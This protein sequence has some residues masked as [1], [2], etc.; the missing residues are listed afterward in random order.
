[1]FTGIITDIGCI[2]SLEKKD[3]VRLVISTAYDTNSIAMGAS[4]AVSGVCLTVVDKGPGWFAADVSAETFSC[5]AVGSWYE[6][7]PVNLER[8]LKVGDELGGHIVSGHVD[9]VGEIRDILQIDG[10][11]RFQIAVPADLA[12]YIAKK[13]SVAV[14]GVSLTINAVTDTPD[15]VFSV[16]LVPHSLT[17]TAF[18]AA[19][20]GDRVNLEIDILARYLARMTDVSR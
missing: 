14:N 13:G 12:P 16:N 15:T 2:R 6:G 10:S 5:T 4:V 11:R 7:M 8:S 1:M 3:D 20:E 18:S 19:K 17:E 9:G